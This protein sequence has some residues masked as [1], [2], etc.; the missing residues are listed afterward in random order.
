MHFCSEDGNFRSKWGN[1]TNKSLPE[2]MEKHNH[3][4]RQLARRSFLFLAGTA[5]AQGFKVFP[6][7]GGQ[8]IQ[9]RRGVING[10]PFYRTSIDL[11][12]P[13]TFLAIGLAKNLTLGNHQGVRGH[14][15]FEKMVRRYHAALVVNGAFFGQQ[16]PFPVLGN[17][18]SG[19]AVLQYNPQQTWGTTIGIKAGNQ[20]EIVT[21]IV[22]GLPFWKQYWFSLTAGPRLLKKGKVWLAPRSE[23]FTDPRVMSVARRV[24][25]G[26]P[27]SGNPIIL[28]TFLEKISLI[29]EAQLMRAIGC[30]EAMN[31]DGGSS[32]AL[33]HQGQ[34]LVTPKRQL[35]NVIVAYDAAHPAPEFL[36]KA[37][38]KFN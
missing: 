37:W 17:L 1:L 6:A 35:T 4:H 33:Y 38:Q 20:P 10:I 2:Q 22:D 19:G 36:Q 8:I 3:S 30:S 24:A 23:G 16:K 27:A 25:I 5:I 14:E 31:L 7:T 28:V 12:A 34:M 21:P 9:L 29:Q 32:L 18:I 26:F 15:P 11:R 13:H